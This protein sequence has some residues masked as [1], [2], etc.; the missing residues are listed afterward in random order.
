M[1]D[2]LLRSRSWVYIIYL[3]I[4]FCVYGGDKDASQCHIIERIKGFSL[5]NDKSSAVMEVSLVSLI[6]GKSYP[7]SW[8][9]EI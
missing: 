8:E 9:R 2:E 3:F 6:N 1:G 7:L 4:C 5:K